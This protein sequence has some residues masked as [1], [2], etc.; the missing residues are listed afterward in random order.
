MRKLLVGEKGAAIIEF[1]LVLP[2]LIIIISGT[3]EF[4]LVMYNK[5]V[6]TNASREGARAGI[7]YQTPRVTDDAIK[8]EVQYYTANQLVTFGDDDQ[9]T[10]DLNDIDIV[11][12]A[13][14]AP[15]DNLTITVTYRYTF[16]V[17]SNFIPGLGNAL[18][19]TA[20]T[21]MKYE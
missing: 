14:P 4:G 11:H 6:I 10:L 3:I 7:V 9:R 13:E 2:L 18:N 17:I 20:R 19:L 15:G 12:P 5:Q 16:L 21:V 8:Q 1:A